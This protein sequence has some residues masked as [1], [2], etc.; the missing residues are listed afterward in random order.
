[1]SFVEGSIHSR[2]LDLW[3]P[4]RGLLEADCAA[5]DAGA[6][7]IGFGRISMS[8]KSQP[9]SRWLDSS[10]SEIV[11]ATHSPNIEPQSIDQLKA[12]THRLRQAHARAKDISARQQ[13]EI[14]G[15]ADPRGAKRVQDNAGSV[16]K[17]RVLFEAIQ[18]VDGEL[19]RRE[20][21]VAGTPSQVELSRHALKLKMS[22]QTSERPDPGRSASEGM[23]PKKRR[24]LFKVGTTRKEIGRV[25]QAGKVAQARKDSK[26]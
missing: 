7:A 21:N 6:T 23:H 4:L 22:S 24:E 14:L 9:E 16:E 19:S 1:M 5:A 8:K 18:R 11:N 15:K 3:L 2:A 25:S 12:L 26:G 13:R 17:V 10:E 20:K